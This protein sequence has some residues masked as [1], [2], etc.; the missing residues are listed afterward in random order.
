V[1]PNWTLRQVFRAL[2][3]AGLKLNVQKCLF[4]SETVNY[5]GNLVTADGLSPRPEKVLSGTKI[6][7]SVAWIPR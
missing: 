7:H 2:G 6:N 3:K 1:E 4:A 5:L